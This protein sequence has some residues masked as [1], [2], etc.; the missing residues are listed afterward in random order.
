MA[1]GEQ[2]QLF[3]MGFL[4]A[5]IFLQISGIRKESAKNTKV[6]HAV[7]AKN[8]SS[9]SSPSPRPQ[10]SQRQPSPLP[11]TV[12]VETVPISP[13]PRSPMPR[14]VDAETPASSPA[15]PDIHA[16]P[17]TSTECPAQT[18]PL[19]EDTEL[20]QGDKCSCSSLLGLVLENPTEADLLSC[21]NLLSRRQLVRDLSG[22]IMDLFRDGFHTTHCGDVV[23]VLRIRA[24]LATD[25]VH[26]LSCN[27][28][29]LAELRR[30]LE[31][32]GIHR[33]AT[34]EQGWS[35]W[36]IYHDMAGHGVS[37]PTMG[38]PNH[39]YYGFA[40]SGPRRRECDLSLTDLSL[41]LPELSQRAGEGLAIA[42]LGLSAKC[43]GLPPY[44]GT[45]SWKM[46]EKGFRPPCGEMSQID[47]PAAFRRQEDVALLWSQRYS[48]WAG[49]LGSF[50]PANLALRPMFN[51]PCDN[52][53]TF[54]S[55]DPG[56]R[57]AFFPCCSYFMT[58]TAA[59]TKMAKVLLMFIAGQ[60]SI[61]D[62]VRF[63]V[64]RDIS[65]DGERVVVYF[66]LSAMQLIDVVDFPRSCR[67][68][69]PAPVRTR[70][71]CVKYHEV[72]AV[73]DAFIKKYV[74]DAALRSEEHREG[75]QGRS[76]WSQYH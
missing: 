19:L 33:H 58:T 50:G 2:V 49:Q 51:L 68:G 48:V 75:K 42:A 30:K 56:W 25:A 40:L 18:Q 63:G 35:F 6:S 13:A 74:P 9:A 39:T 53:P 44:F 67:N 4:L 8:A 36:Q 71:Q 43:L 41:H 62:R 54:M 27:N 69:L 45:G 73:F 70:L 57:E 26:M 34:P 72:D 55:T 11:R 23:K 10:R 20:I 64:Q 31:Q 14:A 17:R 47:Y 5:L 28:P 52:P 60:F 3:V 37:Y 24:Q 15:P 76:R 66:L 22:A 29:R 16:S 38:Q 1:S 46:D 59:T 12:D 21:W 65:Y 7:T 61:P 32:C